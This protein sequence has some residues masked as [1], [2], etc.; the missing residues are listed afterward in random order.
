M[1]LC[2]IGKTV[3]GKRKVIKKAV[4]ITGQPVRLY[5]TILLFNYHNTFSQ[6]FHFF[7]WLGNSFNFLF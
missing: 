4:R 7:R 3:Y 2:H 5:K 1:Q 6:H